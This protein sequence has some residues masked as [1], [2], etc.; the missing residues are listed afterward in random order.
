MRLKS[1]IDS[2]ED[3]LQYKPSTLELFLTEEDLKDRGKIK[4]EVGR[5]RDLGIYVVLHQPTTMRGKPI[6]IITEGYRR[7]L[8]ILQLGQMSQL[9]D[10]LDIK[11]VFH[12]NYLCED[13]VVDKS[14]SD[15]TYKRIENVIGNVSDNIL[16]ENAMWSGFSFANEWLVEEI[17]KPL[18][19]P[20]CYD[21]SHAFI[22]FKGDNDKLY[23]SI[24]GLMD[25]IEHFHVVDSLGKVHDSLELGKGLIDWERLKPLIEEKSYIFEIGLEDLFDCREMVDSV[26]YFNNL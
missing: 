12:G 25:H 15:E 18:E 20:I 7:D 13:F 2:I 3:R 26:G 19:L 17:I 11:V 21:I 23:E 24:L 9:A 22:D 4:G 5:L 1:G 8:Y 6:D 10:E 14:L 16:W